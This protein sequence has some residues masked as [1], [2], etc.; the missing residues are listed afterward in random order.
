MTLIEG[1]HIQCSLR[2]HPA[3]ERVMH[4]LPQNMLVSGAETIPGVVPPTED[5]GKK[6]LI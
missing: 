6:H 3:L 1:A 2:P 4:L 5:V